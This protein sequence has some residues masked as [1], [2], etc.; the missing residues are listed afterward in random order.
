MEHKIRTLKISLLVFILSIT[1]SAQVPDTLWTKAF[2]GTEMDE[3]YSVKETTDGGYII[4][5]TTTSFGAGLHD[6]YLIKTDA[7]GDT[8]WTKSIGGGSE[9][10]GYSVQ[11]TIDGGYII[12]GATSS[13]GDGG[14]LLIKTD[15]SGDT[16]WVKTF[17]GIDIAV[18]N[19]VQ[20]IQNGGYIIAGTK[21]SL[22]VNN[23]D[24][25]LI[26]TD[27]KGDSVWTKTI[28]GN[29]SDHGNF[30]QQVQDGG[31]IITGETFSFGAGSGDVW[32]IKTNDYGDT[33]WTKTFGGIY[34]DAGSSVHQTMDGGYIITG[35]TKSYGNGYFDVWLIK[36]DAYG[37]TLWTRTFGGNAD[38]FGISVQQTTDL[39]YII[40]GWTRSFGA[41]NQDAWLIKTDAFGDTIWTR[42]FGGN[43]FDVG[44]SV[45]PTTD[46]GYILT[47]YTYSFGIGESDVWLIKTTP[48]ISDVENETNGIISKFS[49]QQNYPNPFNPV[50]SL[51]YA[52]SSLPE[53]KAGR[54]LVTL[55]VYDLLGREVATLV[56]EE[57]P[58]GEYEVEFDGSNLPSGIYFYQLR[59]GDPSTGS[60]QGYSE[61]RKMV[62]L[63]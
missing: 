22:G 50:T 35:S 41:G 10:W 61:T 1:I 19:S 37:D 28:G 17:N 3:G 40:I 21:K 49:L 42:T 39:G 55:K 29:G 33:L 54:Q 24:V 52:I 18:G 51:Q 7:L 43:N 15:S 11:Q 25:Y 31:Y 47:G 56:N 34:D 30:I 4:S 23:N 62:L 38:D 16:L 32:L 63:R 60:G 45:Q 44:N 12:T 13:F 2:G 5:G 48:D 46:G 27:D 20:E 14:I 9:D 53:G 59:A 6:V 57:K 36:T 26:K 8:L 58:A